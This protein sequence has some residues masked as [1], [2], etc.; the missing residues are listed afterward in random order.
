[1]GKLLNLPKRKKNPQKIVGY[2]VP[3][4]YG[5]SSMLGVPIVFVGQEEYVCGNCFLLLTLLGLRYSLLSPFKVRLPMSYSLPK[6]FLISKDGCRLNFLVPT[7]SLFPNSLPGAEYTFMGLSLECRRNGEIL[8][9]VNVPYISAENEPK[10]SL[11]PLGD[12]ASLMSAKL[13]AL[14][15]WRII[16]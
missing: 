6:D 13:T 14:P 10:G 1:M 9:R 11:L 12:M 2:Q 3:E 15:D 5:V 16:L 4:K 8:K 7:L